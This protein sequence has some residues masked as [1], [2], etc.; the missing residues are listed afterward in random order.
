[1][2][3][4]IGNNKFEVEC[5]YCNQID[6]FEDC[7]EWDDLMDQMKDVNWKSIHT[8]EEWMHKCWDCQ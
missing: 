7:E 8:G 4:P 5:N 2:I 1:M 3:N 6:L